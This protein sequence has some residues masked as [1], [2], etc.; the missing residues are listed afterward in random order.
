MR[1]SLLLLLIGFQAA[2]QVV[3]IKDSVTLKPVEYATIL[4]DKPRLYT[5]TNPQGKAD[6][7]KFKNSDKILIRSLGYESKIITYQKIVSDSFRVFLKPSELELDELVV[8]ANRWQSPSEHTPLQIAVISPKEA[9]LIQPQTTADL[10][11]SSGKVFI[12]KSQQAG[13]SPMIRGFATNRLLYVVDGVRTNTAIFRGGNIQNVINFD[14]FTIENTEVIL[15]AGS[16]LYGSDAIGGVMNFQTLTP[17]LS[18][19]DEVMIKGKFNAR[20]ST[21]NNEQTAHFDVNVGWKKWAFVTSFSSWNFDHLKQGKYGPE[22]YIKPYFVQ[23]IDTI[24]HVIY[25]DDPLKQ[26]PTAYAQTNLMQKIRFRPN[27]NWDVQYGFH[28]SET[29]PYGRY[30]RHNRT[31]NGLP[32]YAEWNYGPQKWMMNNLN[33]QNFI[34]TALSDQISV[35]VAYQNFEESR[36][37]RNFNSDIRNTQIEK[38]DAYSVNADIIKAIYDKH[39]FVYGMEYVINQVV[40]EGYAT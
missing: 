32:R 4:S 31:K 12:Q 19:T 5:I 14:P 28:Y 9:E 33:L 20:Y 38:V 40:S 8:S 22:E 23:R 7:S 30:D 11:G 17:Q 29:S 3:E 26:I 18:F 34:K 24:D 21:A 15:G 2:S 39:S 36:I 13:G 10:L 27:S 37:S 25:Q 1:L 16:V 35:R 6:I